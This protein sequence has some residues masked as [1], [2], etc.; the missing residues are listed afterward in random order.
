MPVAEDREKVVEGVDGPGA[1]SPVQ[2]PILTAA[3]VT[4]VNPVTADRFLLSPR[5]HC[6]LLT[7]TRSIHVM[8][9]PPLAEAGLTRLVPMWTMKYAAVNSITREVLTD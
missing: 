7:D 2:P 1:G 4:K 5:H 6:P 9:I 3:T 8:V